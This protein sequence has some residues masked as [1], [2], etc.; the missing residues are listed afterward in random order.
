MEENRHHQR[1]EFSFLSSGGDFHRHNLNLDCSTNN[2]D[3]PTPPPFKEMD[4]FKIHPHNSNKDAA[5]AADDDHH[6][7]QQQQQYDQDQRDTHLTITKHESPSLV[8]HH[9]VN[10][11]L[12]LTCSS[13]ANNGEENTE[14]ELSRV[15]SELRRVQ[16][17][18]HKL[19]IVLDQITKSYNQ[20]QAHLHF[21]VLHKQNPHHQNIEI[22]GM[23]A[24]QKYVDPGPCTKLDVKI[25]ASINSDDKSDREASIS[26]SNN[27]EVMSN[28]RDHHHLT[29]K[30]ADL[31][32]QQACPGPTG[33]VLDRSS[34]QSLGSPKL[35]E[36]K[37]A[38]HVAGDQFQLRKARVSVRARSEAP[39][40]SDGCQWRKYGQKMAKGNP[41]PRAYYRCTMGSGC[42]VR[43][44]VQRCAED[45]TVLIT[46]YEGNHN[47]PLPPPATA[48]AST[49]SAAAKMLLS[50]TAAS[51]KEALTTSAG[52]FSSLPYASVATLSA[53]APFP[54]ITLDLTHQYHHNPMQLHRVPPGAA[55]TFPLPLGHP[56]LLS[57]QKL[58]PPAALPLLQLGQRP[59]TVE[60]MSAAI[61]SDP[62]FTAALAAAISSII[63]GSDGHNNSSSDVNNN[64][65][66]G[67]AIIPGSPQLPQSCTTFSTN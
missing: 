2:T 41:C 63:R 61:A 9:P 65:N 5:A 26:P 38:E 51:S 36:S 53:S 18:N 43:K 24:G 37:T 1:R 60:T 6:Q 12:N 25:D 67:S 44:Q 28:K 29:T 55:V 42:P 57:Q 58:L 64:S 27:K 50:G 47:H 21:I 4:F 20:L 22:N 66:N 49:T 11:G 39:M 19:R 35:E 59:P 40:I 7:Q 8:T 31:G 62:N 23:I 16:E 48:M 54:T 33:D 13:S 45:R 46:T 30:P 3:P 15:E 34:S 32:K 56:M 52:Y 14:T 17:E 10:T